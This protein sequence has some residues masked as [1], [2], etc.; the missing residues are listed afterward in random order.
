[1]SFLDSVKEQER[2]KYQ[3]SAWSQAVAELCRFIR[4][5]LRKAE[6]RSPLRATRD[7]LRVDK[8]LLNRLTIFLNG[9]TVTITPLSMNDPRAPERGGCIAMRS[10]NGVTYNLLWDGSSSAVR[11]HWKLVRAEDHGQVDKVQ[12]ERLTVFF[13]DP[14][15]DSALLDESTLDEAL[16]RLFGLANSIEEPSARV[17]HP[18]NLP[19]PVAP[20]FQR[21]A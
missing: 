10:T 4:R 5:Y 3:I 13:H 21:S 15:P 8:V 7:L 19:T 12:L 2:E 16:G 17:D 20:F 6:A 14:L 1:M 18:L 11:D 9:E